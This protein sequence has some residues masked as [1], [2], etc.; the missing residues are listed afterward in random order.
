M[1]FAQCSSESTSNLIFFAAPA[2]RCRRASPCGPRPSRAAAPRSDSAPREAPPV[3]PAGGD[4]TGTYPNPT[5]ARIR[6][7]N[8]TTV[9][10]VVNNILGFDGTNWT[11]TSLA[12][13]P[14]NYWRFL[15]GNIYN[16]NGGNVGIG[17]NAPTEKLQVNGNLKTQGFIMPPGAG[18]GKVLV[19]DPIGKGSW[20][21]T[22]TASNILLPYKDSASSE[23]ANIFHI[24]QLS[25]T[26][27][28]GALFGETRSGAGGAF[29]T[30]GQVNNASPGVFSAGVRGENLGA[31]AL[32]PHDRG[33]SAAASPA[34]T[35]HVPQ[36]TCDSTG[37]RRLP[38]KV[39]IPPPPRRRP[40]QT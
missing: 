4:L 33:S 32:V 8:V 5:V 21:S 35:W 30:G 19:S 16:A 12:T 7:V 26:S 31:G 28:T 6:G 27:T 13:H 11:P 2:V 29:G 1:A 20:S 3:G 24:I 9:A 34:D 15:G 40:N 10:P 14:D 36:P 25:N 23:T 18:A 17:I 22:F 39:E 38:R 37:A